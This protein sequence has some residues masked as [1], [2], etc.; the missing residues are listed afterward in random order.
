MSSTVKM[1]TDNEIIQIKIPGT[2]K[3]AM[4]AF[5]LA[6]VCFSSPLVASRFPRSSAARSRSRLNALKTSYQIL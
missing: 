4:M 2:C 1:V 6:F 5:S 3:S